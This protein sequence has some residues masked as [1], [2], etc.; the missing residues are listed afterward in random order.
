MPVIMNRIKPA[1][2]CIDGHSFPREYSKKCNACVATFGYKLEDGFSTV[3]T[4]FKENLGIPWK[5]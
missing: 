2:A 4:V 3:Y 5:T 1:K